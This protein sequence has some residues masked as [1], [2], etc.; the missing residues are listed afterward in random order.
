MLSSGMVDISDFRTLRQFETEVPGPDGA[1][2]FI[3]IVGLM[4]LPL[5][6][7]RGEQKFTSLVGPVLK[8]HEVL[9]VSFLPSIAAVDLNIAN[10]GDCSVNSCSAEY[11]AD[12]GQVEIEIHVNAEG[13]VEKMSIVFS[14][15]I[16]AAA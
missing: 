3:T 15:T 7:N 11:D 10:L 1:N 4:R 6:G 13:S 9:G 14:L 12:S 8:P 2:R 16:L 5:A